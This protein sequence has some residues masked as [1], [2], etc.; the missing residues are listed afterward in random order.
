MRRVNT[1]R[2][3]AP[4]RARRPVLITSGSTGSKASV[5]PSSTAVVMLI[6]SICR[7]VI[8]RSGPRAPPPGSP[9][10][11]QIGRQR[12]RD[13]LAG[14]RRSPALLH[15]GFDRSEIV[16]G[17]HHRG[18]LLGH[19]RCLPP[20]IAI[21]MSAALSAGASLTPSPV[22]ATTSPLACA[23]RAP[24]RSFCS[25]RR[26]RRPPPGTRRRSAAS[27]SRVSSR[28]DK[29]LRACIGNADL[30]SDRHRRADMVAGDHLHAHAGTPAGGD[31]NDRSRAAG[32]AWPAGR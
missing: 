21:P 24:K 20:P 13:E 11:R 7:G 27:S 17:E 8:G 3:S 32:R 22:I 31:R 5:R 28:P 23:R 15:R 18:G 14:C 4:G 2:G 29:A 6:H 10:P 16:V 9:K 26:A 1:D 12:P 30:A 25:V 19:L